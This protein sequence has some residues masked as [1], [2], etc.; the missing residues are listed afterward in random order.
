MI[1]LE[2]EKD[3][4]YY[5]ADLP[6]D[7]FINLKKD[8]KNLFVTDKIL[9]MLENY[10]VKISDHNIDTRSLNQITS[11]IDEILIKFGITDY[12][13]R[14]DLNLILNKLKKVNELQTHVLL[15]LNDIFVQV[16]DT[17]DN[18]KKKIVS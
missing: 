13:L 7:T 6:L 4:T 9:D 15:E 1:N 18:Y 14:T 17:Q 2:L 8:E 11:F 16:Q 3:F 5:N 10:V 12:N